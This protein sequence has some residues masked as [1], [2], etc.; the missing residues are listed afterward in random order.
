MDFQKIREQFPITRTMI[1]HD[2]GSKPLQ[3][4][5][6]DHAASTHAPKPVLDKYI[7]LME[8]TYANVH[9]GEHSLSCWS[10]D[11]FEQVPD[12][13]GK[14]VGIKD[15]KNSGNQVVFSSNTTSSLD[16][17][18][19][20][21]AEKGGKVLST[22]LE[23]HSNDLTHRSRGPTPHIDILEDGTLNLDDYEKKLDNDNI[24]LV[25]VTAGSNV[26]GYMPPIHKMAKMAHDRGAK[27]LIDAA[28]RLAHQTLEVKPIEHP[29]HLDFIAAAG[30][31]TYSPFGASFLLGDVEIFDEA[32][33]YIPSGGTVSLV[34]EDAAFYLTGPD[35]HSYG[36]PNI[37]GSIAFGDSLDFL[38]NIGIDKVRKHELELLKVMLKGLQEI[39]GVITYGDIPLKER[40]GVVSFNIKNQYHA[41]VSHDLDKIGGIATRNGCFC[42][43]PYVLRLLNV[44]DN[45]E[46]MS[47]MQV[48]EGKEVKRPG[49]VRASIGVYN[50]R[51]EV[52]HFLQT[53]ETLVKKS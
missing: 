12:K 47:Q 44:L 30:H 52:D 25:A 7:E 38:S 49:A 43:H 45:E 13:I 33:P 39:E 1:K 16:L 46:I 31:K 34:T 18:S 42:A 41:D 37:A 23:H 11:L 3:L 9:R 14:F 50:T 17:A 19:H 40:I 15:L 36:T 24:K 6:M 48:I 35:R 27:I 53:V 22:L 32:A 29:E 2:D 28:Q 26:T 21:F 4:V 10:T 5:Y 51:E 20:L 8:T